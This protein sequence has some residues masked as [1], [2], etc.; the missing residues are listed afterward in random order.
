MHPF[1][2]GLLEW[3]VVSDTEDT[4]I[5]RGNVGGDVNYFYLSTTG[6]LMADPDHV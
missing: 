3:L 2:D 6:W 1:L 5:L 4:Q